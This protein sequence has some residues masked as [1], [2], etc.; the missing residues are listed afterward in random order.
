[1]KNNSTLLLKAIK[2]NNHLKTFLAGSIDLKIA[3]TQFISVRYEIIRWQGVSLFPVV[4]PPAHKLQRL[5][6]LYWISILFYIYY[7]QDGLK[8]SYRPPKKET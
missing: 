5:L 2:F 1:M 7:I 6:H 8:N 3:K 4:H